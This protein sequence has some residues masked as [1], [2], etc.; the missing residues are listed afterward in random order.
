[1][2]NCRFRCEEVR[3]K[4]RKRLNAPKAMQIKKGIKAKDATKASELPK[5]EI[6][7][8]IP[9]K[10]MRRTKGPEGGR[11]FYEHKFGMLLKTND[12]RLG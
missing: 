12:L 6:K 2:R 1:M 9:K 7:T 3:R 4:V 11:D 8:G 5:K 10:M